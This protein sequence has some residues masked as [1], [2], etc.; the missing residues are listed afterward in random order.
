MDSAEEA[1]DYDAMDHTSVNVAF[2]EDLLAVG[3]LAGRVLD[4]GTGT[5][6]IPI[7]LCARAPV[8]IVAI[9]LAEHMLALGRRNVARAGLDRRIALEKIDA[10]A[11]P[12]PDASFDACISNSI[13]HHIPSPEAALAEMWR[14]TRPGG[15]F[16]VRDLARPPSESALEA[17]VSR[18]A[19]PLPGTNLDAQ[20]IESQRQS[21]RASLHAA[22]TLEEVAAITRSL[23]MT[24]LSLSLTS[25]RH[26]TL[27]G[28]KP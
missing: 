12:W 16:F 28:K 22:L 13:V 26:W 6:L 10:K 14:V 5:A 18:Y 9:D 2:C 17:F 11:L 15:V 24:G 19:N 7:E 23:G 1:R 3:P 8:E 4:V 27:A 21:F 25:D 20:A